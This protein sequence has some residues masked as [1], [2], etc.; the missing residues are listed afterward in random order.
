MAAI[1]Q[2]AGI[3]APALERVESPAQVRAFAARHGYPLVFKPDVGMGAAGAFKVRDAAQLEAA[4]TL[5]LRD[6]VV[7]P[8]VPGRITSFDGFTD[9]QGEILF[10]SSL[11]YGSNVMEIVTEALDIAY[12]TR[13]D[14]PPRLEELGRRTVAAFGLRERFF[15]IEFFEQD[16]GSF[17]ALEVNLRPPGG[18]TTDMMNWSCDTDVYRLWAGVLSGAHL[19]EYAYEH[20][21]FCAHVGRRSS[22]R[23]RTSHAEAVQFLGPALLEHR[24]LP[25]PISTAMGDSVYA[26]RYPSERELTDAVQRLLERA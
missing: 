26:I 6:L 9:A 4:L 24:T 17:T 5:P 11:V 10:S 15:H 1:F 18:F 2:A 7:Q 16:D 3:P 12:W 25:P 13:R 8:F 23:Y 22:R 20:R 19:G 21:Y 14:I